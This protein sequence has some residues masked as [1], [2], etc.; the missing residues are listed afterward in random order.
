MANRMGDDSHCVGSRFAVQA[1]RL[2]KAKRFL[3]VPFRL[4][5]FV[6]HRHFS[7]RNSQTENSFKFPRDDVSSCRDSAVDGIVKTLPL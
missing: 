3:L 6:G 7:P 2:L 1:K 5:L 4:R